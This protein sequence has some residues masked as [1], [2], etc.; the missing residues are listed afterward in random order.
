MSGELLGQPYIVYYLFGLSV[1][2][3]VT[4]FRLP[5]LMSTTIRG[6]LLYHFR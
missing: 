3:P 1:W 2:L 6:P 4:L 5:F